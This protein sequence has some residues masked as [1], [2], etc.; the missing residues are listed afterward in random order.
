ML[1]RSGVALSG[2]AS[3]WIRRR[4]R[5]YGALEPSANIERPSWS[6]IS[7]LR[8]SLVSSNMMCLETKEGLNLEIVDQRSE[9][10]TS[11]LQ[12]HLNLVCRLLLEKKKLSIVNNNQDFLLR[13][14]F[15][16]VF[17]H[18]KASSGRIKLFCGS[19]TFINILIQ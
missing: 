8:P 17:V 3:F 12:S 16:I 13:N 5:S 10:H 19:K 1:T 9:E 6:T 15:I 7:R 18:G 2:P 11:E 14:D 4:V